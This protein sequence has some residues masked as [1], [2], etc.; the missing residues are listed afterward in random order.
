M[1]DLN[2]EKSTEELTPAVARRQTWWKTCQ[3]TAGDKAKSTHTLADN[4]VVL[5]KSRSEFGP[6]PEIHPATKNIK[7]I[8]QS[9][10]NA[11][12]IPCKLAGLAKKFQSAVS[13]NSVTA[14]RVRLVRK[15]VNCIRNGF[16]PTEI[17]YK[18]ET[19]RI[20]VKGAVTFRQVYRFVCT[21]EHLGRDTFR[22]SVSIHLIFLLHIRQE[23]AGANPKPFSWRKNNN[24]TVSKSHPENVLRTLNHQLDD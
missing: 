17:S 4:K 1:L 7:Y 14:E 2:K 24:N 16:K 8:I 19:K 21:V 15:R 3:G 18:V 9:L 12:S 6:A 13:S 5:N 10:K 20:A 11:N 22:I 23:E